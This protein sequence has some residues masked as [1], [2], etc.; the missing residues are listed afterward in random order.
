M[1]VAKSKVTSAKRGIEETGGMGNEGDER[2]RAY[3][4][5][6]V[7]AAPASVAAAHPAALYD[8]TTLQTSFGGVLYGGG[9]AAQHL[10]MSGA[11]PSAPSHQQQMQS[12]SSTSDGSAGAMANH[13][14]PVSLS[15]MQMGPVEHP[16]SL[17]D[18]APRQTFL[19]VIALYFHHLYPLLPM[20][21]RPTFSHDL[22]SRR[23]EVDE[24]FLAFVLSLTA[25][26]LVQAPR[27]V[28]PA[29]W[30]YFRRLHR[31][32]HL[33]SRRM[34]QRKYD[35]AKIIHL[36]TLYCDHVSARNGKRV[37]SIGSPVTQIYLGSTGLNNAANAV[38]GEAIRTC[39]TV[40]I[41][42]ERRYTPT[43]PV[44][45]GAAS[46]S[47]PTSAIE[48]ELRRRIY[49]LIYGSDKTIAV[50]Q[51]EPICMRDDDSFNVQVPLAV[52]DDMLTDD[53]E[54]PQP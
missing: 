5:G 53:A 46:R 6:G 32:C 16:R 15:G 54:Y 7:A 51:D 36:C 30:T 38:L 35:P 10:P 33:T 9:C 44:P 24:D 20:V 23:D 28:V 50:L 47:M 12:P 31:L 52:D 19:S 21:H 14:K 25:Y 22:V 13:T 29:P 40:G 34:Q 49:F 2:W 11:G 8:S 41:H 42:D 26:T 3:M 37:E 18:I 39:Y 43:L 48:R 17:N 27:S 1:P 45:A 4:A